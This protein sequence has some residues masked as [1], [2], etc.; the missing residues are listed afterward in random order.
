MSER[1][2]TDEVGNILG[3][4]KD[5]SLGNEQA[6]GLHRVLAN[7]LASAFEKAK[8]RGFN[9][10]D[11]LLRARVLVAVDIETCPGSPEPVVAFHG[12]PCE[13]CGDSWVHTRQRGGGPRLCEGC[14]ALRV[15]QEAAAGLEQDGA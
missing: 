12:V 10:E 8:V 9:R 15:G 3:L 11:F 6:E 13:A 4:S 7:S 14:E 5:F 2:L 1:S